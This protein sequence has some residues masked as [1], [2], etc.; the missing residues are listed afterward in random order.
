MSE[1]ISTQ[2]AHIEKNAH[3]D[4]VIAGTRLRVSQLAAEHL[5]N[6]WSAEELC[7]QH[8]ELTLGQVHSA[9][10]YYWDH[11]AELDQALATA[12]ALAAKLRADSLPHRP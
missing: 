11:R 9:L 1:R 12:E 3:G 8:P 6:G 10:A 5:A 4:V 7:A 2:Y